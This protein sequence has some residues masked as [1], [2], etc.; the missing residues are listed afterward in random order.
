MIR[1]ILIITVLVLLL[2]NV[3]LFVFPPNESVQEAAGSFIVTLIVLI[4]GLFC[5]SDDDT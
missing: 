4:F 1:T 3:A 5:V 2:G